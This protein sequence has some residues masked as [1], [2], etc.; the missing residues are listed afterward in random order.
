MSVVKTY[1]IIGD[2]VDH[3]LSPA[4]HNAAFKALKLNC[5]YIA[6]KVT[7]D[8]LEAAVESLRKTKMAGFN[9]TM[10]HKVE[11]MKFLD[12]LDETCV[13]INAVNTVNNEDGRF[14][15]YNTDMHGFITPLKR[16]KIDLAGKTVLVMGAGGAARA[17][18]NALADEHVGKV[19]IANRNMARAGEIA[20]HTIKLKLNCDL[21]NLDD[22]PRLARLSDL[23]VNA[24]PIGMKREPSIIKPEDI[25]KESVVYD[26]VYRPMET[27]LIKSAKEA[28]ATYLYGYEM[29]V[30]QGAK[31][32]EI[33]KK[34]E[35]PRDVMK[36]T[37][38]GEFL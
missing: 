19:I 2:P 11:V 30:E 27:G 23:I 12:E 36:K 33:W 14:K 8:E 37:L 32:F 5:T 20:S 34:I 4:M 13:K 15:G 29:L 10:P 9:V 25:R 17:V 24:T 28:N 6:M 18:L 16:R 1:C 22:A 21:V 26:L 38:V 7:K 3:S 35:A 31:A